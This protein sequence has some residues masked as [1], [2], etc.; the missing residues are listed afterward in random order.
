M[1]LQ[2]DDDKKKK[3]KKK[4][5]CVHVHNLYIK[6]SPIK[7]EIINVFKDRTYKYAYC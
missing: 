7:D 3:T 2:I 5:C 4:L 1:H 6:L